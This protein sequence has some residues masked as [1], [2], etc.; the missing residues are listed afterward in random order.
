MAKKAGASAPDGCV[1]IL[2]TW[3]AYSSHP[4]AS[5]SA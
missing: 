3:L 5:I 4:I 2:Q 1:C